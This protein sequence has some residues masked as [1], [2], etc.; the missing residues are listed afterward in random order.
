VEYLWQYLLFFAKVLTVLAAAL[1]VLARL[2]AM[3][4]QRRGPREPTLQVLRL[5]TQRR[6]LIR[7]VQRQLLAP[8]AF[9]ELIKADRAAA[10]AR[11][12]GKPLP[13]SEPEKSR[14]FVLDYKGDLRASQT[15]ALRHEV[16]AVIGAARPGDQ[17]LLRLE[18]P[19]GVVH[20]YGLAASQ[21]ERLRDAGLQLTVAVDQVAASGGYMMAV[22][23]HQIVAAP[24][25]VVGSIGVVAQI[26]NVHRWLQRRDIDVE[27]VT[28][29]KHKRSLTVL[30]PNTPEGREQMQR[31]ITEI[32]ELFKSAVAKFRPQLDLVEVADGRSWYGT[33]ALELHLVDTL[34]TS[35]A[36]LGRMLEECDGF[37]VRWRAGQ[38][39]GSKLS[40]WVAQTLGRATEAA[41][42]RT[43]RR[44]DRADAVQHR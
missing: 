10:K 35:D 14:L 1:V 4:A 15:E 44:L 38:G 17:V 12:K 13:S 18:S 30:G 21:L 40:G 19:G 36:W 24:F 22:V 11:L 6:K 7:A 37:A 42:L 26:P 8:K 41:L 9:E 27:L 32:H 16:T 28:A 25:A 2:A 43:W 5:N 33:A 3:V 31:E 20:G 29:G 23:A 34:E 39:V